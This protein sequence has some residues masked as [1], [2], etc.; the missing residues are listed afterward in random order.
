[1]NTPARTASR[2]WLVCGLLERVL[3]WDGKSWEG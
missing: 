2:K 1:M 3:R